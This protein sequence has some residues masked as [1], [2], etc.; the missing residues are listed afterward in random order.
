MGKFSN[1]EIKPRVVNKYEYIRLELKDVFFAKCN[2]F[3]NGT[4]ITSVAPC[5]CIKSPPQARNSARAS[6]FL[7]SL[8]KL[9]ACKS[10]E[11]SPAIT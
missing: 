6:F 3:K 11:A 8:I 7:I 5:F 10:P 1:A 9:E 4:Q 2:I